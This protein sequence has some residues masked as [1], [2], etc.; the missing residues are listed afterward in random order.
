LPD[1]TDEARHAI[2]Q[3]ARTALRETLG[4]F[5]PAVSAIEEAALDAAITTV[6]MDLLFSIM[7]RFVKEEVAHFPAGLSFVSKLSAFIRA[8]TTNFIDRSHLTP[9]RV[10][11]G[12]TKLFLENTNAQ[13]SV[14]R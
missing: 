7:R 12:L 11:D 8:A 10:L 6:E 14:R 5:D 3:R 1:N 4:K 13:G 2:Y 9:Q